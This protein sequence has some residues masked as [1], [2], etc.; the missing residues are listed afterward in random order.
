MNVVALKKTGYRKKKRG[1]GR[2]VRGMG[3]G[4]VLVLCHHSLAHKTG[5]EIVEEGEERGGEGRGQL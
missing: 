2:T 3:K 1:R 4:T 5:N